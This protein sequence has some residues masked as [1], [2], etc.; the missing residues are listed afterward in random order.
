MQS[1]LVTRLDAQAAWRSSLDRHVSA[2][3]RFLVDHELAE[4]GDETRL[5]ALRQ[6][7]MSDRLLLAFVAEFSRGKSELINAIF[8][9]DTGRRVLP[10]TPGRTTMCPVELFHDPDEPP[11]LSM[12]PIETRLGGLSLT[13]LRG[14]DE[15]WQRTPLDP[16][17]P[18]ALAQALA[19]V[20]R[21]QRVPVEMAQ[22]LGFW[23]PDQ[24]ADNPPQDAEGLVE[25]PA[26]RHALINYPHPLLQRGLVVIDT[27]GLNAIGA[28]PELTLSLLP[29][30]HATV[31]IL[32]ADAGVTKSD[33]S[34]WRE[35]LGGAALERFVVLN[36]I[37][38][39]ADPLLP[40]DD[41][42]AQIDRQRRQTAETLGLDPARVFPLSAREA[43]AARVG[44]DDAALQRSR[45]PELEA[46]LAAELLPR[47]SE[48]L[49]QATVETVRQMRETAARRLGDRRRQNA[50]QMLE[51]R[52]L[53][54]KSG[55]KVRLMLDRVDAEA[56]EFERC[57]ARLQAMRVVQT[58]LQREALAGLS[59]EQLRT[60]VSAMQAAAGAAGFAFG[61]R[62]PF[63]LLFQRLR[64]ALDT[65]QAK[66]G[67]M[68][69]M[70][71]GSFSQLNG[72]FGFA[73]TVGIAPDLGRYRAELDL[74][75][76]NYGRYV[77]F[78]QAWRLAVPGFVE[79]FRRMLLSKLRVVF[80]NA[81]GDIEMWSKSAG[82]QVE[83]QLRERRKAFQ[84]RREALERIQSA[85]GEL[86]QR[87]GEVEAQDE[88]LRDLQQRLDRLSSETVSVALGLL[89]PA[90][91]A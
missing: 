51:L 74:I 33:L 78:S 57:T 44:R 80:E 81:A 5:E 45:L 53:R 3:A 47:Q 36:K 26:W 75:A 30:A 8:F 64:S 61:T 82:V 37:D 84:R 40:A 63:E 9:A 6:R 20:T 32:A 21:T 29:A 88:H 7:L 77:G 23:H 19:A 17:H 52:G 49:A 67:E 65:A 24:A 79:Q 22:R 13:E 54:G 28:E 35:H 16:A 14:R 50:E 11:T 66:A 43:L 91:A 42:K 27:P 25:I 15:P 83:Q 4:A 58:R 68:Q 12:L 31:F 38:A 72:E 89:A 70:L 62:K 69:R 10:A 2:C 86:E 59:S 46:A 55:A 87:I 41:V 39:L 18:E 34:V 76:Q 90:D 48:L 85:A 56:E 73:F 1:P 71:D 60:E